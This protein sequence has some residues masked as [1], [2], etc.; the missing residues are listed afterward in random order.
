[1]N[2]IVLLIVERERAVDAQGNVG[3]R[4]NMA[5]HGIMDHPSVVDNQNIVLSNLVRQ[6]LDNSTRLLLN[7][8]R[9]DYSVF[10][11]DREVT[12]VDS[13]LNM[14]ALNTDA[15]VATG[16]CTFAD[17]FVDFGLR[18]DMLQWV[19]QIEYWDSLGMRISRSC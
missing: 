14:R 19:Q 3:L 11:M 7:A 17:D 1:M 10:V 9:F 2:R 16:S 8:G 5:D 12:Q 18:L 13:F 6:N 15:N 4:D